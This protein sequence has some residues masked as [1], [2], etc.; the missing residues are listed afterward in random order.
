MIRL[1]LS[2]SYGT[3]VGLRVC[4]GVGEAF[5]QAAPL[6]LTLWYKRNELASRAAIF[7]SMSAVAG[8]FNGIIAY[9]IEKNMDG[10]HGLAAWKW[11]FIIEGRLQ[12]EPPSLS[13]A[14]LEFLGAISIG[15]GF[16]IFAI[17]PPVPEKLK[18]GFTTE[19]KEIAIRRSKEAYNILDAKIN[20]RQLL[21]LFKDPKIY[22]YGMRALD[23]RLT[24]TDSVQWFYIAA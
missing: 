1:S 12:L 5:I 15:Y 19:Q 17:L 23:C 10:A 4:V 6:Y 8:A 20:P 14:Y 24:G 11:I 18:W 7:F 2:K 13:F 9:G 3:V 22:F 16:V 21:W